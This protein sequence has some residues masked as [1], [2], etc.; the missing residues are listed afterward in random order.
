[1]NGKTLYQNN[2]QSCHGIDPAKNASNIMRGANSPNAILNAM[3]RVTNMRYLQPTI[4][5]PE[6]ADIAAYL[7]NP[8]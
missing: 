2:C 6:A 1:V 4:K 7:G 3:V 5:S 8:Q